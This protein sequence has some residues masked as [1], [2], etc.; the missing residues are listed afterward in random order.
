MMGGSAVKASNKDEITRLMAR[1]NADEGLKEKPAVKAAYAKA[2]ELTSK[3]I[4][5]QEEIDKAAKELKEILDNGGNYV[6]VSEVEKLIEA[7]G[8]VSL[9]DK[10]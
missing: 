9:E 7:I 1:A 5:P 8:E 4:T 6:A 2:V 3:V 10:D